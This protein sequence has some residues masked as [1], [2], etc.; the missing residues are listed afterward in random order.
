MLS[1]RLFAV[2]TRFGKPKLCGPSLASLR[3]STP[4]CFVQFQSNSFILGLA[5]S[6]L[7]AVEQPE[8]MAIAK[9]AGVANPNSWL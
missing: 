7:A 5:V 3:L 2:S 4:W 1:E 8:T 6:A 9:T